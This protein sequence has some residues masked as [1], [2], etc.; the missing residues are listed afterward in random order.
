MQLK[1]NLDDVTVYLKKGKLNSLIMLK[2]P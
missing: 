1:P 2:K